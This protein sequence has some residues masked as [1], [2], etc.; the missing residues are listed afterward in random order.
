LILFGRDHN[1]N[2]AILG[3]NN[4]NYTV[5]G[6]IDDSNS[7]SEEGIIT[8]IRSLRNDAYNTVLFGRN[9]DINSVEITYRQ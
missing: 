1:K 2:F 8:S 3:I 4:D 5:L 7:T 6:N 9:H